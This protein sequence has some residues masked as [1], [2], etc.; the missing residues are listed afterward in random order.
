MSEDTQT[1]EAAAAAR[2]K[3]G[4]MTTF[5]GKWDDGRSTFKVLCTIV[6][7]TPAKIRDALKTLGEG[8]YDTVTGRT[9][10]IGFHKKTSDA[11]VI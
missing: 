11:F 7:A 1:G 6:A 5:I 3:P 4:P 8:D 9:G 10:V 2:A